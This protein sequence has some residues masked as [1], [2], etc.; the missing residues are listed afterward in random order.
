MHLYV[1]VTG[2]QLPDSIINHKTEA[3]VLWCA[4]LYLT[5]TVYYGHVANIIKFNR[6]MT[7]SMNDQTNTD[8]TVDSLDN[9]IANMKLNTTDNTDYKENT[10]DNIFI[11]QPGVLHN[12][13][14]YTPQSP[15][16]Q[17]TVYNQ[18][19]K[20]NIKPGRHIP[21]DEDDTRYQAKQAEL[22]QI[23]EQLQQCKIKCRVHHSSMESR[24]LQ[25]IQKQ[26]NTLECIRQIKPHIN[27]LY[28]KK[29]K[30]ENKLV[31]EN[32]SIKQYTQQITQLK[33]YIT[34]LK[35]TQNQLITQC[36]S[37]NIYKQYLDTVVNHSEQYSDIDEL[38]NRYNTLQQTCNDLHSTTNTLSIQ[39]EQYTQKLNQ[40]NKLSQH[41]LLIANST[42]A[43]LTTQLEQLQQDTQCVSNE[44]YSE[45]NK[46]TD[47]SRIYSEVML[48]IKNIYTRCC[49]HAY[50]Q[51]KQYQLNKQ[52]IHKQH[53]SK[54][55]TTATGDISK[56]SDNNTIDQL[57]VNTTGVNENEQSQ[58]V[59]TGSGINTGVT[60]IS[61]SITT[62]RSV[63]NTSGITDITHT[64]ESP[65]HHAES[66]NSTQQHPVVNSSNHNTNKQAV[67]QRKLKQPKIPDLENQCSNDQYN[68]LMK[69]LESINDKITD[70]QYIIEC[71]QPNQ[72]T[73]LHQQP[74][75]QQRNNNTTIHPNIIQSIDTNI[76]A[77]IHKHTHDK[78]NASQ[79]TNDR[80]I[81]T[82]GLSR[83]QSKVYK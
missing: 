55:Y 68:T 38:L 3:I 49:T 39:T 51:H 23:D 46:Q 12:K 43:K 54:D 58:T 80:S 20:L 77:V 61:I 29:M 10:P 81:G 9:I 63:L 7:E 15:F 75:F 59:M 74:A 48:S 27:E 82:I 64:I 53:R 56:P 21:V 42:I 5:T 79:H 34:Q 52:L 6:L 19:N 36:E 76:K 28:T 24:R 25:F 31:D 17:L 33:S 60:D 62:P 41:Q 16:N 66:I 67:K 2:Y 72:L 70:L 78:T 71:E 32:Q 44:L 40:L 50:Q 45:Y 4:A 65:A 1:C 26:Y 30:A 47:V 73:I 22:D 18:N 11:T 57:T 13:P 69:L 35:S 37:T 8:M 14:I 83:M